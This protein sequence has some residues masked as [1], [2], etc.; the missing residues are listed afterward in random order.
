LDEVAEIAPAA[1]VVEAF[2]QVEAALRRLLDSHGIQGPNRGAGIRQ[3]ADLARSHQLITPETEQAIAGLT[4]LRNLA[5]H[6]EADDLSPQRAHEFVALSH[7]VLY[8]LA[9]ADPQPPS[10][11]D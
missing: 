5:A 9:A 2:G 8:A 1:A 3:L 6:G 4:V 11:G 10:D 7:A